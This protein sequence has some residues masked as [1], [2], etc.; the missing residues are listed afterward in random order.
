MQGISYINYVK[1]LFPLH[2]AEVTVRGSATVMWLD[3]RL[4]LMILVRQK[5]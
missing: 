4:M 1:C 3:E 2:S 5:D